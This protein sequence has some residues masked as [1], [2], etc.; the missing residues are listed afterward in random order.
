MKKYSISADIIRILATYLVVLSHT[1]DRFVLYTPLK[2]GFSWS[3]VYYMH[4]FSHIAV[5]LFILLSGYLLLYKEKTQNIKIFY[6]RRLLRIFLPL[7]VWL[8]IYYGYS[9]DWNITRFSLQNLAI[10][11]WHGDIWHLYFLIIILELYLIAPTLARFIETRSRK[12]QTILFGLLISI[13]VF[14]SLLNIVNID[15]RR[16]SLTMFIPYIGIFYAG[17]YLRSI[18]VSKT[19]TAIFGLA[20]LILV[21]VTNFIAKGNGTS[22]IVFN[23]SPTV[24]TMTFCLFLALKDIH[25]FFPK[26]LLSVT[27]AKIVKLVSS[28]TLGIFL[29]HLL[30][31]EKVYIYFHLYPWEIH[32]PIIFFAL[33]PSTI[34]FFICFVVIASIRRIPFVKYITG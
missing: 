29:L 18:P 13:S 17:A 30:V 7:I 11:L 24:L 31:L 5:P 28:T 33:L 16:T 12:K 15:V 3:I 21:Q 2:S 10:A 19:Q 6:K 4:T 20:F 1:T 26:K 25:Q 8:G 34:T 23:Y 32:T 9:I 22:F 14:C 27:F